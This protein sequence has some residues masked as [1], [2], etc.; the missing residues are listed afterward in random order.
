MYHH[1]EDSRW[2]L[3]L[4]LAVAVLPS[5]LFSFSSGGTSRVCR[6]SSRERRVLLLGLHRRMRQQSVVLVGEWAVGQFS[7]DTH[8]SESSP[9]LSRRM[10]RWS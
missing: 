4:H 9:P 3:R 8:L 2:V 6:R 5:F 1:R 10:P 7:L